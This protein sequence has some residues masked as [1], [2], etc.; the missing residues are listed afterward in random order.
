MLNQD[1]NRLRIFVALERERLARLGS[2]DGEFVSPIA[3]HLNDSEAAV[4]NRLST[5][6]EDKSEEEKKTW[7][8]RVLRDVLSGVPPIDRNVHGFHIDQALAKESPSVKKIIAEWLGPPAPAAKGSVRDGKKALTGTVCRTFAGQFVSLQDLKKATAFDRLNGTQLARLIRL[9]GVREVALA[10]VRIEAVEAVG[11]FLRKFS[12]E[13]ARAI[14]TRING[15]RENTDERLSLAENF[16]Q[17]ALEAED[18][19]PAI[20]NLVGMRLVGVLLCDGSKLRL[21][22]A[23]LKLPFEIKPRLVEIAADE[24]EKTPRFLRRQVAAEVENLAE[25]ISQAATGELRKQE[26]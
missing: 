2:S 3:A 16:V 12:A 10:C 17:A 20:L 25:A 15:L 8:R 22:Y 5:E 24:R 19:P 23:A 14:A 11:A 7:R 1:V 21:S 4:F 9:S 26:V 18:N 6:Y 13:D